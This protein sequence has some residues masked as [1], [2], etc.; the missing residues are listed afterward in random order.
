MPQT[1]NRQQAAGSSKS[2]SAG[3]CTLLPAAYCLLP[4]FTLVEV[5]LSITILAMLLASV[6]VAVQASFDGYDTSQSQSLL[7]Q[8]L[9]VTVNRL[10]GEIRTAED[11]DSTSTQLTITPPDDSGVDS[12]RYEYSDGQLTYRHTVGSTHSNYTLTGDGITVTAFNVVREDN[13]EGIPLSVKVRITLSRGGHSASATAS[14][15]IRKNRQY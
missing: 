11:V 9:R 6:A 15:V 5:M 12:I 4:G 3:R 7:T 2:N 14:A 1:G 13:L 8:T 10:A